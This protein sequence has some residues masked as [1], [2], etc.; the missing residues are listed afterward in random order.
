MI[1]LHAG[2]DGLD[3]ALMGTAPPQLIQ[4]LEI[5]KQS[6]LDQQRDI[7]ITANGVEVQ[8]GPSGRRGGYSCTF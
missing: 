5:A 4:N 8:V 7:P 6:A 2:F 1:V 3:L